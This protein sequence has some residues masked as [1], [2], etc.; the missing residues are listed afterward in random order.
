MIGGIKFDTF[1]FTPNLDYFSIQIHYLFRKKFLITINNQ[2]LHILGFHFSYVKFHT[3]QKKIFL[4]HAFYIFT[5][6]NIY[7]ILN[8]IF[9]MI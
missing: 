4:S 9:P 3:N 5:E 8:V 6:I 1:L 2:L 7:P